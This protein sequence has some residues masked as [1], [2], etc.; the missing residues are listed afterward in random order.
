MNRHAGKIT[1]N[2]LDSQPM[3]GS[4]LVHKLTNLIDGECDIR[5][6]ESKICGKRLSLY[7]GD[8]LPDAMEYRSANNL[9]AQ[10]IVNRP[11]VLHGEMFA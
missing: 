9:H 11:N 7:D 8:P 5:T 6:S 4:G 3:E 10:K 2:A 1:E